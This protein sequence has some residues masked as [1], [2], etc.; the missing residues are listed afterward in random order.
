MVDY[1]IYV[2]DEADISL[3]G[4][5]QLDG[6]TQGD[7]SHLVN[8]TLTLNNLNFTAIDIT[9]NDS[10][11]RD[12]DG[13]QVLN[14]DQEIDGVTYTSGTRVEAEYSFVVSDGTNTWTL[15]GFNV[16]NSSPRF[17]TVEGIAVIGG[18]GGFPPAGVPLTIVSASEGP[19]FPA[20]S[21]ATPICFA[22]GTLIDTQEG[23]KPVESLVA[24]EFVSTKDRGAMPIAWV[25]SRRVVGIGPFAPVRIAS[26]FL[27]TTQ[28]LV[29]SQQHRVL[30]EDWRCALLFGEPCVL[31]AAAHLVDGKRIR[32]EQTG[33]ITYHH[34]LL[35]GH[36][37]IRANGLYAESLLPGP[38]ALGSLDAISQTSL[39][40]VLPDME[41]RTDP[42]VARILRRHEAQLLIDMPAPQAA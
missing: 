35:E 7:G 17:G 6:Q 10:N 2:L 36:Q 39:R 26:G 23:P 18:P 30:I 8:E 40:R 42:A 33:S 25:G 34:I 11:F 32:I 16:D 28:D 21:F 12:N 37:V 14:G 27:G 38:V 13:N 3:S 1:T 24:G 20:T 19:N 29:V 31:A 15:I 5:T 9:D 4:G 41:N 22:S